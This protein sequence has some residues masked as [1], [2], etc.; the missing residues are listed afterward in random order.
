MIIIMKT[1]IITYTDSKNPGA[2]LQSY[3]LQ[4][5]VEKIT[6]DVCQQI[7]HR[8]FDVKILF[9][10]YSVGS[11]AN[12]AYNMLT[13]A[14]RK[15]C[16]DRYLDY[17][18]RYLHLTEK[19]YTNEDRIKLNKQFDAFITGSDQV[20]NCQKGL[21]KPFFL[22]FV[23]DNVKKFSYAAS[24]G[25]ATV[26]PEYQDEFKHLI[27]RLDSVS[28]REEQIKRL[29][30]E[31][32]GIA[33]S[34]VCDPVFLLKQEEWKRIIQDVKEVVGYKYIFVFTTEMTD[35]FKRTLQAIKKAARLK[36]VAMRWI[37]GITDKVLLDIGPLQFLKCISGSELVVTNSFHAT[38][39]SILFEKN[40]YSVLH[41]TRGERLINL[42]GK[43]NLSERI[44]N[45]STSLDATVL[46]NIHYENVSEYVEN[47]RNEGKTYLKNALLGKK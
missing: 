3:A 21:Y 10:P 35:D 25:K 11:L 22:D 28:V 19:C 14:P 38:A 4:T 37:P 9:R 6:G 20:W 15:K 1:A 8:H 30:T 12:L 24:M 17:R 2:Q 13:Y 41:R 33:S 32:F 34:V 42:L 36:I 43:L 27:E 39:F 26:K 47:L 18:I 23:E 45:S 7:D 29:L 46:N 40:F 5:A 31:E 44:V 16:V